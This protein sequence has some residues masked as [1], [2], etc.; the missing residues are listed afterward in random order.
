[1]S[2]YRVVFQ[3]SKGLP[4]EIALDRN[5]VT[6]SIQFSILDGILSSKSV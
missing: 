1:M 5:Q 2:E 3:V 4:L 6:D